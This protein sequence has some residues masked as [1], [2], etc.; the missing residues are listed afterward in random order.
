MT[1]FEEYRAIVVGL[2]T[3]IRLYN[4]VPLKPHFYIVSLQGIHYFFILFKKPLIV[5]TH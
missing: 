2:I 3:K 1:I 4:F 5:G